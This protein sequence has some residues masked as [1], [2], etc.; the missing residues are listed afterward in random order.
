[1]ISIRKLKHL[2][3]WQNEFLYL[4]IFLVPL[5][6]NPFGYI[7]FE[8]P[9]VAFVMVV[10]GTAIALFVVDAFLGRKIQFNKWV[11]A[12]I[13]LWLLSMLLSTIFSIA[14]YES[15]WGSYKR[16][17]GF[18][19]YV[20][21]FVHFI[22]CLQ[23]F[24]DAKIRNAFF[25]L[26]LTIGSIISIYAIL[27]YFRLDPFSMGDL[28]VFSG[29]PYST[30]GQPNMLGQWLIFPFFIAFFHLEKKHLRPLYAAIFL[31]HGYTI[32]LTMNRATILGIIIAII[33]FGIYL[34]KKKWRNIGLSV[35]VILFMI[36]IGLG[37]QIEIRSLNSRFV[38]WR[39]SLPLIT[40][41]LVL[42]SGPETYYQTAQTILTPEIYETERLYSMPSRVHNEIYQMLL[43]QGLFGL[44]L[45]F[46]NLAVLIWIFFKRKLKTID[47]KIA[48]FAIIASYV[49]LQLSFLFS[50]HIIYLMAFWAILL[51]GVFK[52]DG[53]KVK[54]KNKYV[55]VFISIALII[56]STF[57][58]IYARNI[59]LGDQAFKKGLN[60]YFV[61]KR[62][63]FETMNDA[64]VLNPHIPYY[65]Q[66]TIGLFS[67][68]V[69]LQTYPSVIEILKDHEENLADITNSNF[70]Y[71][72][73]SA[74]LNVALGDYE[75]AEQQ[76]ENALQKAPLHVSTLQAYADYLLEHGKVD[77]AIEQYE[78]IIDLAPDYI[79]EQSDQTRIFKKGNIMFYDVV[80]KLYGAYLQ[81]GEDEKASSL[82]PVF[83]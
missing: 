83:L 45:Y 38:L 14:P 47:S 74:K 16:L 59:I 1:M 49:S 44:A 63:A 73:V 82:P 23:L 36:A 19:N 54:L 5:I 41:N 42:G 12:I 80:N 34:L 13:G 53:I 35:G 22:I 67:E 61:D 40:Q 20:Y 21:Y 39:D 56:F 52:F 78:K 9:K 66:V 51:H 6:F 68:G 18:F 62:T 26:A 72:L 30:I 46:F 15:F 27:Q 32:F 75:K 70:S 69:F 48:F 28:D 4:L 29:R 79:W 57:S 58:A 31:L 7:P 71:Y 8:I 37:S 11:L 24:K 60:D 3:K 33:L 55:K 76:F 50:A 64:I 2:F 17:S 25:K 81:A 10:G 65:K 43:D 77:E